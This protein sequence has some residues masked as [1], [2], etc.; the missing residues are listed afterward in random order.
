MLKDLQNARTR[1]LLKRVFYGHMMMALPMVED[2]SAPTAY[3]DSKMIGYNPDFIAT[4]TAGQIE[5][6]LAHELMHVILMH[7]VRRNGRRP[8]MWNAAGDY[9]INLALAEDGFEAI[10]DWLFDYDYRGMS[11][12]Q[13][14]AILDREQDKRGKSGQDYDDSDVGSMG[15]DVHEPADLTDE[16]RR[17]IERKIKHSVAQAATAARMAGQLG[18]ALAR[19]VEDIIHTPVPW[20]DML[21]NYASRVVREDESWSRRNRRHTDVFLPGKYGHRVG[22]VVII[23]DTSGSIT[24][25]ELAEVSKQAA[26]ILEDVQPERIRLVWADAKVAGEQVFERGEYVEA[27]P[28]G[29]GGTDMRVPLSHVE[30]YEPDVVV[31]ITDGYTPWPTVEPDYPLIVCCTTDT[32]VPVG[33]VVRMRGN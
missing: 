8:R 10:D 29:G 13:I 17:E 3:T 32:R 30:Q 2:K 24:N 27:L 19:L 9:A 12:D 7:C 16:E 22:E 14:Y 1:M 11:A 6:L 25:K 4:L 26:A 33:D 31:L 20:T 18:G 28:K 15:G 5:T 23:G 21:R